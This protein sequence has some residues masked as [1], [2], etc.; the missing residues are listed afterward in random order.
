MPREV[1]L[2]SVDFSASGESYAVELFL[3]HI[4]TLSEWDSHI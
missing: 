1:K 4:S 2:D 3:S